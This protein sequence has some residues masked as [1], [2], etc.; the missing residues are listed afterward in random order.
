MAGQS[1]GFVTR[2]Q[3]TAEILE[4]LVDQALG[5]LAARFESTQHATVLPPQRLLG[6]QDARG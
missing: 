2:E 5:V 3:A 6:S 4:E 1:V